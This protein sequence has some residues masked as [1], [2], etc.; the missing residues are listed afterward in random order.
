MKIKISSKSPALNKKC[1]VLV[2]MSYIHK[3]ATRLSASQLFSVVPTTHTTKN[4]KQIIY[5]DLYEFLFTG[6]IIG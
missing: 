3:N 4:K 6:H 5:Y 1:L 2:E